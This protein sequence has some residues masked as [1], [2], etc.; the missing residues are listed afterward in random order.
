LI[1]TFLRLRSTDFGFRSE[2]VLSFQT[3]MFRYPQLDRQI[4]FV[5]GMLD[6]VRQIPGVVEAGAS[7]QLPL[8]VRDSVATFYWLEGQPRDLANSQVASM[9]VVS[10]GYFPTIGAGLVE[11]RFFDV[12]D[13]RSN[14]PAAI[15]NETFAR[16]HFA[17]R[18]ALGSRFKYGQFDDKGY[19]YTIIGVVK[20]VRETA[21][22]EETRPTVYR[23]MDQADQVGSPTSTMV[24]R[25]TGDP[26]SLVPAIRQAIWSVDPN[27]PIWRFETLDEL[28]DRQFA[29]ARQS[30]A[31]M[32]AFALLALLLA[33]LGLYGVLS[34]AVVQRT[35][36]IGVRMALGATSTRIARSFVSRGLALTVAGLAAGSALASIAAPLMRPLLYGLQP[37]YVPLLA[38]TGGVLLAVSTVACFLPARRASR[39]DPVIALRN[40]V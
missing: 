26:A 27:Q 24:V 10:R 35:G 14:A 17:G 13:R 4:A 6:N 37:D 39:V 12:T 38:G 11:G 7:N 28:V 16:R 36:E 20:E 31:L 9:R 25:T 22:A 32:S 1:E 5:D 29:I 15:V 2:H 3:S 19:W 8:R 18:S 23:V 40:D 33:A 34:C 30:T 21:I